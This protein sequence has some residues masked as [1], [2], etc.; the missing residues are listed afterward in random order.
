LR[1]VLP[2]TVGGVNSSPDVAVRNLGNLTETPTDSPT[3]TSASS[4]TTMPE[5]PTGKAKPGS[6][7]FRLMLSLCMA[8]GALAID[9]M[10]PAFPEIRLDLQLAKGSPA[11]AGLVTFFLFGMALGQIPAGLLTDRFGRRIALQSA[12]V[13]VCIMSVV[14]GLAPKLGVMLVVRL[15]WGMCAGAVRVIIMASVRDTFSGAAMAKEMSF[16]MAVFFVAPILAPSLGAVIV[17]LVNWRA[18]FFTCTV[19][20]A[21]LFA[22]ITARFPETLTVQKRRPLSLDSVSGAAKAIAKSRRTVWLLL[23]NVVLMGAFSGYIAGS[24]Q[25]YDEVFHQRKLFPILFGAMAAIMAL[26]V[27]LNGRLVVRLGLT[28]L[29]GVL[30]NSYLV[31][32]LALLILSITTHGKPPMWLFFVL[33]SITIASHSTL[34][35]NVNSS[36]IE[37]LGAL[38]GTGAAVLGS[39]SMAIGSV[40]GGITTNRFDGTITPLTTGFALAAVISAVCI[41][42]AHRGVA[43]HVAPAVAAH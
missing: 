24:Q 21:L 35:T 17:S 15:I 29:I 11:V 43:P 19:A 33:L 38:A 41:R 10:L 36:A 18:A 31:G 27:I 9:L 20:A 14:A 22:W 34:L 40:L 2:T 6:V 16:V 3:E 42:I 25:I 26:G 23:S 12:L 1:Q 8:L 30:S 37:P 5:I 4:N 13:G 28:H 32:G 7:E 39:T